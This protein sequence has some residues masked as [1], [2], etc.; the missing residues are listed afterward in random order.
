MARGETRRLILDIAEDLLQ[1]RGYNGFS[2]QHI[3]DALGIKKAAIH[4]HFAS[5]ADLGVAL[6]QRYRARALMQA[7]EVADLDWYSQ[8]DTYFKV[9]VDYLNSG[10]KVCPGGVLGAEFHAI[11]EAMQCE[12]RSMLQEANEYLAAL[13]ENGRADGAFT[14]VGKAENK[15]TTMG[16]SLQGA[17]QIARV[18]AADRFTRVVI[19]IKQEL[20]H[21]VANVPDSFMTELLDAA[22]SALDGTSS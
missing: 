13:L 6:I 3:S 5:K 15:A 8:L 1:S 12:T 16:A 18:T 19:Q 17:L 4:Y 9:F 14:F 20:T 10:S 22:D 21:N 2:Y 7:Q 11:P